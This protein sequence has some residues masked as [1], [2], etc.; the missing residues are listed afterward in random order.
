MSEE[1]ARPPAPSAADPRRLA[2]RAFATR[3]I[4]VG[5]D[6]D[7]STGATIPPIYQTATYTLEAVGRT[8]G[9]DYSRSVNPT[10]VSLEQQIASLEGAR[11]GV[12]FASGMAAVHG[13]T[14]LLSAGDHI[15]ATQDLYGGTYRLFS[16]ILP[17]Y[18][19]TTTYVDFTDVA[20]V[21]DALRPATKLLWIET[22][23]N[24][25]LK[26][27]DVAA[28]VALRRPGLLI[29]ADN[30][31]AS[32][33]FQRPIEQGLDLVMHS[34]TKY[35]AGHSDVIGGIVVTDDDD[36][37]AKLKY[38]QN[39]I[40]AVPAPFDAFLTMRGVKTLAIR[41]REHARNAQAIAEFL[42]TREDV[43]ETIYPGLPGHPH[44]ALAHAQ[45]DGFGAIV[46]IRVRGGFARVTEMC[47][48]LRVFNLATSLGGV[49]SLICTPYTMTHGTIPAERK[50]VLG[51]TEDLVRLSVGIEETN[52]LIDDLREALDATEAFAEAAR[53]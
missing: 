19:V 12:A 28:I 42:A 3:A 33:Y 51:I 27:T 17:R 48:H 44:H 30:T 35:L 36:L 7:P 16:E 29:G 53:T 23:S 4:R 20:A 5:Q 21:R 52:D 6:A 50:A 14:G 38:H 1:A 24:P 32:P 18:G 10:R 45:M 34:T 41:M 26:I 46:T 25:L 31:F 43:A 8:K 47:R 13:V 15:V 11:H 22:P 37:A 39:S 2:S 40:G 9:F 49:E